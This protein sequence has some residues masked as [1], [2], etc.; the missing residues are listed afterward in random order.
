MFRR[1]F[2]ASRRGSALTPR[3]HH[4]SRP[5]RCRQR[6]GVAD[7][8][9]HR[10]ADAALQ[11]G[12]ALGS[13]EQGLARIDQPPGRTRRRDSWPGIAGHQPDELESTEVGRDTGLG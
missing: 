8:L 9:G 10:P 6:V 4:C 3:A 2:M 5:L 13:R 12:L 7:I 1:A 11:L